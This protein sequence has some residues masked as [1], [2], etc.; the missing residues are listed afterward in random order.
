V[1]HAPC[2]NAHSLRKSMKTMRSHQHNRGLSAKTG[3][4]DF[5]AQTTHSYGES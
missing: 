1:L 3:H 2:T 5:T 4:L